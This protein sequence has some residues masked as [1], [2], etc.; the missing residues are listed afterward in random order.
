[1]FTELLLVTQR[2][3]AILTQISL[4]PEPVLPLIAH[5]FPRDHADGYPGDRSVVTLL[6]VFSIT[7][8]HSRAFVA[9][10]LDF[11]SW[12]ET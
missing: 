4:V 10:D 3:A 5:V 7:P 2:R 9:H 8:L 12:C 11:G 1:M 6:R